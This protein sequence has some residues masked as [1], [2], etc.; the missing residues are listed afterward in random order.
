VVAYLIVA[1]S[2]LG[3]LVSWQAS[4]AAQDADDLDQTASQQHIRKQQALIALQARLAQDLRLLGRAQEGSVLA[5]RLQRDARHVRGA[6]LTAASLRREARL[7]RV[8]DTALLGGF[9]LLRPV[10][11]QHG[12]LTYDRQ[13]AFDAAGEHVLDSKDL[14]PQQTAADASRAHD[15]SANFLR[16]AAMLVGS[17]FFLTLAQVSA[18]RRRAGFAVAGIAIAIAGAALF[19]AELLGAG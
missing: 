4:R 14:R 16:V 7:Q 17:L 10:Q 13:L 18:R 6:P 12:S 2:I 1:V 5:D 19:G 15:R 8:Q 11:G 9:L 3:P